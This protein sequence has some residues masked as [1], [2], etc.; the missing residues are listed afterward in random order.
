[1][2][3][4]DELR[5]LWCTQ[6]YA[7][8]TKGEQLMKLIEK[9]TKRFDRVIRVRNFLECAGATVV[10]VMYAVSAARTHDDVQRVG[11]IVISASAIWIMYFLLRY[12]HRPADAD[13][14]QDLSAYRRGLVERYDRQIWLLKSV[15]Y[16][17]LLP[18]Y[19]GLLIGTLG[20]LLDHARSGGI[21]WQDS[22][23][24]AIYTAFFAFVWW[25][26]EIEG[27]ARLQAERARLL[28]LADEENGPKSTG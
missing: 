22:I 20:V 1:M 14:S 8:V 7:A 15:K 23:L 17:Y 21:R 18:P 16:W 10:A 2:N 28:S 9:K 24:P 4:K 3:G 25:L 26:N 27:V 19:V 6:A 12:G 5:E 11:F 13:P